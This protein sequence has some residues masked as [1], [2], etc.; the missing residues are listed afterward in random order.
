MDEAER[1]C[2]R[3]AI[4]DH[5]RVIALGSPAELIGKLEGEHI[6][7]FS[8]VD[9]E[10]APAA[11][12][13]LDLPSIQAARRD[14]TGGYR[15]DVGAPHIALPA[16]LDRLA[17]WRQELTNLTTRHASLEDVFVQL[18]G[19][20]MADADKDAEALVAKPARGRK[21]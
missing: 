2:D 1:L 19:R 15:L 12:A 18:T 11:E 7:E 4:V 14:S 3:V 17:A 10:T 8:V 6:L 5:G 9:G 16:L 20:T 13:F 21:R